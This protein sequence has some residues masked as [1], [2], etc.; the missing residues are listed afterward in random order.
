MS[1]YGLGQRVTRFT[2]VETCVAFEKLDSVVCTMELQNGTGGIQQSR[3]IIG[4]TRPPTT[5][6][7]RIVKATDQAGEPM[8]KGVRR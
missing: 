2:L 1:K 4:H 3:H 5:I 6:S 7:R 8:I